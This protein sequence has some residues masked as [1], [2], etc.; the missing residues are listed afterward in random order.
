MATRKSAASKKRAPAK[1]KVSKKAAAKKAPASAKKVSA[2]TKAVAK[3]AK[4]DETRKIQ[5]AAGMDEHFYKKFPRYAAYQLLLKAKNRTMV[6]K[7]FLDKIEKLDGVK[8]RK[9][10]QGIVQKLVDKKRHVG[11]TCAKFVK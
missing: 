3:K 11:S 10:A 6:V 8:T 5:A 2:K 9:Q 7:A 4:L 1:R